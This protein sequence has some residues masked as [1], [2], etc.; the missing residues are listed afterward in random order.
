M[1]AAELSKVFDVELFIS[2]LHTCVASQPL[3]VC[4]QLS[5]GDSTAHPQL[6][7]GWASLL[8]LLGQMQPKQATRPQGR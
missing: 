4:D 8:T 5:R 2:M 1:L 6:A 3:L 7:A